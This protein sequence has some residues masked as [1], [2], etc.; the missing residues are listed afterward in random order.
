MRPV[1]RHPTHAAQI[2]CLRWRSGHSP[3]NSTL[4]TDMDAVHE[5]LQLFRTSPAGDRSLCDRLLMDPEF[6]RL[7][8][9]VAVVLLR[10]NYAPVRWKDDLSQQVMLTIEKDLLA[11]VD[12]KLDLRSLDRFA[13]SLRE[14][15]T[16]HARRAL[17]RLLVDFDHPL[18][19]T[20][21]AVEENDAARD[22]VLDVRAAIESLAEPHRTVL[23]LRCRGCSTEDIAR[24]L[25]VRPSRA[26][27]LLARAKA[28]LRRR[29]ADYDRKGQRR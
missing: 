6:H 26:Y 17:R 14:L 18:L 7:S 16:K 8:K 10:R 1:D 21:P 13:T 4:M 3:C 23:R 24:E 9:R 2:P 27:R 20:D 12:L 22:I 28:E 25:K 15:V 5:L 29:L 19:R 11:G